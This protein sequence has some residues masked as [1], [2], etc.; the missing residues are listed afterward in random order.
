MA[1]EGLSLCL[2]FSKCTGQWKVVMKSYIQ[3]EGHLEVWNRVIW[4]CE[5]PS[6]AF[7]YSLVPVT[8][9]LLSSNSCGALWFG[10]VE[11]ARMCT[12]CIL[13][14]CHMFMIMNLIFSCS[15]CCRKGKREKEKLLWSLSWCVQ[16]CILKVHASNAIQCIHV[17]KMSSNYLPFSGWTFHTWDLGQYDKYIILFIRYLLMWLSSALLVAGKNS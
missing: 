4:R 9:E 2:F 15:W 13:T 16:L 11:M 17:V 7:S 5:I 8:T 12:L 14:C 6:D 10:R 3:T 1:S